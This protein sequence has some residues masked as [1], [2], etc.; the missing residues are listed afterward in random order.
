[1]EQ[2]NS[3]FSQQNQTQNPQQLLLR[4]QPIP[5]Q[6]YLQPLQQNQPQQDQK[7]EIPEIILDQL[8][9]R[10]N[11][12]EQSR[13]PYKIWALLSWVDT[14]Q[15]RAQRAGCGWVSENEFFINKNKLKDVMNIKLN[16]LNVN[17]KTLGFEQ[18]KKTGELCFYKN[19]MFSKTASPKDFERIRN[20]RCKPDSLMHMN[21]HAV[22]FPLL[23]P[24][25]LF[26]MDEKSVNVFKK[27]VIMH[28]EN[29]VGSTLIFAIALPAFTKA[30][31]NAL[32]D[33]SGYI[34]DFYMVQ[35]VLAPRTPNVVNIFD[36][37]V[38][39]ARFG[40][41]NNAP[42]K[43]MQYQHILSEIRPD[44]FMFNAPSL[45]SYF[46]MT[47]HNCFRFQLA[48]NGEYHCYNL[49]LVS[50]SAQYLIDEDGTVYRSWQMMLQSNY[51]L[52]QKM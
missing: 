26:M 39:L 31:L 14:D 8:T 3:T 47:F 45:T 10:S 43:I 32:D 40:P 1:M 16:T 13:F 38:F 12:S 36:F 4:P 27:D 18:T 11:R 29:L 30:L 5:Q 50:S 20:S 49:P 35:Q 2:Q 7:I 9:K 24:L 17:L 21:A 33:S 48:P 41:F 15:T 37:A 19:N 42:F 28:W 25:Q 6:Q 23:E 52:T 51:F 22:Y 34:T 44:F 46:S